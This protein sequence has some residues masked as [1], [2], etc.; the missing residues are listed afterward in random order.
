M[1]CGELTQTPAWWQR[2][3]LLRE[4]G[5]FF[6]KDIWLPQPSFTLSAAL[7]FLSKE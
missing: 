5:I 1:K 2:Q 4:P 6:S 7:C 3:A